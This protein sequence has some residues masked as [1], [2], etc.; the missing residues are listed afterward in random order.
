[1]DFCLGRGCFQPTN[2]LSVRN[3]PNDCGRIKK[4]CGRKQMTGQFEILPL[5]DLKLDEIWPI[6]TGYES[7]EKYVVEKS[8][9]DAQT[10]FNIHLVKLEKPYKAT[11][12]EDFNDE[13]YHRY[14]EFLPQG[15]SFG[16]YQ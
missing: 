11:F 10:I 5:T 16:V 15:Y 8:E 13:N 9:S 1:M 7:N 12:S 4:V 6:V 3:T 2:L 14:L